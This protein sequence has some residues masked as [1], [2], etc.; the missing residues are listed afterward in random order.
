MRVRCAGP[1]K[2]W[3][4]TRVSQSAHCAEGR[5]E[6]TT[7]T[8]LRGFSRRDKLREPGGAARGAATGSSRCA[9]C[10]RSG[11]AQGR[12][13][14]PA[15]DQQAAREIRHARRLLPRRKGRGNAVKA[16]RSAMGIKDL[17][18]GTGGAWTW[19]TRRS[20]P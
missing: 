20:G 8:A 13:L 7:V 4:D 6:P 10:R 12:V 11:V 1:R 2:R 3:R 14:A 9:G 16:E 17:C 19:G 5:T 15:A 18:R